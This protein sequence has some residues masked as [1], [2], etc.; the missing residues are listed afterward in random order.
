MVKGLSILGST[1]SIGTQALNV[2]ENLNINV[3]SLIAKTNVKAMEEQIRR[4]K[5]KVAALLDEKS[6]GILKTAVRDT[7]TKVLKIGRAHV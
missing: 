3:V 1:G 4:Y 2:C 7:D 6:A 5:P